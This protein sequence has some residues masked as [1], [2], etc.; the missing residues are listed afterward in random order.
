[1]A[2]GHITTTQKKAFFEEAI[3]PDTD[4][5]LSTLIKN[6][7][8]VILSPD[9]LKTLYP[10]YL[11]QALNINHALALPIRIEDRILGFILLNIAQNN[12]PLPY[13]KEIASTAESITGAMA[14]ALENSRL[15]E[16]THQRLAESQSI[17]Q[18][19]L[20][21]LQSFHLNEVLEM[22]CEN[23]ISLTQGIGSAVHLLQED[24]KIL[25]RASYC[26]FLIHQ[27]DM[28]PLQDSFLKAALHTL[29]PIII[30]KSVIDQRLPDG[31]KFSVLAIPLSIH[32]KPVG[33]LDIIKKRNKFTPDD[34]RIIKIFADQAAMAIEHANL[35]QQA[36]L[37]AK[38]EERQKMARNLH[39][40]VNQNLYAILLYSRTAKMLISAQEN[41]KAIETIDQLKST[42][43]E[44]L[45]DL[46][47]FIHELRP[48][49][50][51]EEGLVFALRRRLETVEEKLGFD[52]HVTY[53][54]TLPPIPIDIQEGFYRIAQEALYNIV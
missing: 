10:S 36:G 1:M 48:P 26:G 52:V 20:A 40:S 17:Y 15:Y 9:K 18:I 45:N 34:I 19:T 24:Q 28:Q 32:L 4:I 5:L 16:I 31:S 49:L 2:L 44:A 42:T 41:D 37:A 33:V 27:S 13:S 6:K 38:H 30:N 51:E 22:I 3:R 43:K 46:R 53:P 50:L 25:K 8:P 23:A 54:N 39:D 12:L 14:L 11:Y 35:Y 7:E 47:I 29:E 21:M